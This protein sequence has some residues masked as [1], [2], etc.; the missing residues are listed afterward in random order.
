MDD[1]IMGVCTEDDASALYSEVKNLTALI[2]LPLAKWATNSQ[3]LR[4][5][6]QEENVEFKAITEVL[7][8]KWNTKE[9][10]FQMSAKDINHNLLKLATRR[11]ILKSLA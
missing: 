2:S 10:T 9:G 1:L 4:G 5:K 6:W 3:R 8:A 11:L 7:G